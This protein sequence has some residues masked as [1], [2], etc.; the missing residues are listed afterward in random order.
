MSLKQIVTQQLLFSPFV[1]K[2]EKIKALVDS[3]SHPL[4]KS[5][6]TSYTC[7]HP[8]DDWRIPL[9]RKTNIKR[10]YSICCSITKLAAV[11]D[12]G[13]GDED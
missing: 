13:A 11:K 7:F 9:E 2:H 12:K 3:F 1:I 5:A 10:T 4:V 8:G 6:S